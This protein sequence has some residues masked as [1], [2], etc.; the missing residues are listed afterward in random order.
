MFPCALEP[1]EVVHS[2]TSLHC[3]GTAGQV[4]RDDVQVLD[5]EAQ[6][7][8]AEEKKFPE[9]EAGDLLELT[10][11]RLFCNFCQDLCRQRSILGTQTTGHRIP[12]PSR[13]QSQN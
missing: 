6:A 3:N 5:R 2:Y 8:A 10:L 9:F 4:D 1:V 11:V 13:P 7:K 12:C